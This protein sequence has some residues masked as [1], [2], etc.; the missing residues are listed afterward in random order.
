MCFRFFSGIM[1]NPITTEQRIENCQTVIDVVGANVLN[2]DLS[3]ISGKSIVEGDRISIRDLLEIFAGLLEY[4]LECVD[5][6]SE[7]KGKMTLK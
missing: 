4:F 3:H 6:E 5:G 2:A 1:E 7:A